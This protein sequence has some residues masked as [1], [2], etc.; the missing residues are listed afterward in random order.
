MVMVAK[1]IRNSVKY[2]HSSTTYFIKSY[3]CFIA[4]KPQDCSSL[5]S[6]SFSIIIVLDNLFLSFF[7]NQ[8][9]VESNHRQ[10]QRHHQSRHHHQQWQQQQQ[11]QQAQ[12]QAQAQAQQQ[13]QAQAQAQPPSQGVSIFFP[14]VCQVP[15]LTHLKRLITCA[16]SCENLELDTQKK[17]KE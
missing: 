8:N 3:H 1:A 11:Q 14:D 15:R 13:A 9:L 10:Q 17:G 12:A 2:P 4:R 5:N 7:S 16:V 6:S